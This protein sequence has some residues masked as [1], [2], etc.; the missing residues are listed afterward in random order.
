VIAAELPV[1][2]SVPLA[3]AEVA[4]KLDSAEGYSPVSFRKASTAPLT[5]ARLALMSSSLERR[6]LERRF[7]TAMA[8][9][10]PMIET[11]VMISTNENPFL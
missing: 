7:G 1:E 5:T 8:A 6:L 11:T 10:N 3:G 4:D 2:G 9:I